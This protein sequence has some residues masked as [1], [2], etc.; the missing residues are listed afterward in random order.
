MGGGALT[1]RNFIKY[2]DRP[3]NLS[4]DWPFCNC[5]VTF[6]HSSAD[7]YQ[8]YSHILLSETPEGHQSTQV[9]SKN[10]SKSRCILD[11]KIRI[12]FMKY[13]Y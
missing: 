8:A 11:V 4:C 12:F 5:R 2:V 3:T 13:I 9:A 7:F 10:S 1:L 6:G